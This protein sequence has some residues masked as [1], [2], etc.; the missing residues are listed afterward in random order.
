MNK[1]VTFLKEDNWCKAQFFLKIVTKL[2]QIL[3]T[4]F[5]NFSFR[6]MRNTNM[7]MLKTNKNILGKNWFSSHSFGH[8]FK[9]IMEIFRLPMRRWVASHFFCWGVYLYGRLVLIYKKWHIVR[10]YRLQKWPKNGQKNSF[11][12]V[13]LG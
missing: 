8:F 4:L 13:Q 10:W 11:Q 12:K 9:I 6:Y 2:S 3:A 5:K 1:Q 7:K